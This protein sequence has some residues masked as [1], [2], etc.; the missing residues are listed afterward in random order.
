VTDTTDTEFVNGSTGSA[1]RLQVTFTP[2]D[3]TPPCVHN[4]VV[5]RSSATYTVPVGSGLQ[6]KTIPLASVTAIDVTFTEDVVI[7]TSNVTVTSASG[8]GSYAISSVSSLGSS[9]YRITLTTPISAKDKLIFTALATIKDAANNAL[10]GEW[11]N[12]AAVGSGGS[13]TYDSGDGTAG[14]NFVFRFTLLPADF[15][16]DNYV[17]GSDFLT[18][19]A[20]SGLSG[21]TFN[22][23]DA[24]GDGV[25]DS[26]DYAIWSA[27]FGT[28]YTTW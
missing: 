19:Q 25:C 17:D 21:R 15:N 16:Q 12:P 23:G 18:W 8:G 4:V 3:T 22:Q 2:P 1:P 14:G 20:N 26:S 28:D 9:T 6:I 27:N 13:D 11:A 5:R 7:G 24:N 10:D